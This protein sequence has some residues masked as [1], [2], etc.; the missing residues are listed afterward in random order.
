MLQLPNGL[1]DLP[2]LLRER[3]RQMQEN[4]PQRSIENVLHGTL[5]C[6]AKYVVQPIAFVMTWRPPRALEDKRFRRLSR[7][8]NKQSSLVQ[9]VS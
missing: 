7:M 9:K 8:L 1:L 6:F 2:G 4:C 5:I 3:R